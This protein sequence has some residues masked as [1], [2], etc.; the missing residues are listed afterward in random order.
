[1]EYTIRD[2]YKYSEQDINNYLILN[3]VDI[4]IY[5]LNHKRYLVVYYLYNEDHLSQKEIEK[6]GNIEK[7]TSVLANSNT[8]E[9]FIKN[10]TE[11]N[12]YESC[13][14]LDNCKTIKTLKDN[15]FLIN[16]INEMLI[17]KIVTPQNHPWRH[18]KSFN[19]VFPTSESLYDRT[20]YFYKKMYEL[21]FGPEFHHIICKNKLYLYMT[22]YPT[23][24]T[25]EYIEKYEDEIKD[26]I[27]QLHSKG[28]I[29]GD[30]HRNNIMLDKDHQLKLI[31]FETMFTPTEFDTNSVILEWVDHINNFETLEEFIVFEENRAITIYD[32]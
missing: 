5:N 12:C 28:Y 18:T 14:T 3:Q 22:Y 16:N 32:T 27:K 15:V 8:F 11:K 13:D 24:L 4:N 7:V 10:T 25:I 1:M 6:Y 17:K 21:G 29:H 20:I 30:L 9:D 31:D 23:S 19:K 26:F 2:I